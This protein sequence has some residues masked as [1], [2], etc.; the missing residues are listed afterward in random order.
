MSTGVKIFHIVMI[1]TILAALFPFVGALLDG[2]WFY[3]W[4]GVFV[5]AAIALVYGWIEKLWQK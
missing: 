1:L 4:I 2:I 5:I 3:G